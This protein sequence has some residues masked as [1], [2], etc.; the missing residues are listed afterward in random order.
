MYNPFSIASP[1]LADSAFLCGM[2]NPPGGGGAARTE[3]AFLGVVAAALIGA[4]KA[5][6]G[7][8][9]DR[10]ELTVSVRKLDVGDKGGKGKD[11][12]NGARVSG[13]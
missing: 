12:G 11:M 3:E 7:D 6:G 9:K 2:Y 1:P 10:D 13:L 5:V 8:V 4:E